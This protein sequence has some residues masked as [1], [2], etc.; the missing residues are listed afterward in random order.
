MPDNPPHESPT[1]LGSDKSGQLMK[2]SLIT[3]SIVVVAGGIH[4][5]RGLLTPILMATFFALILLIPFNWLRSK[6]RLSRV[7]AL[8]VVILLTFIVSL[9]TVGTLANQ[10]AQFTDRLPE[11]HERLEQRLLSL[12]IHLEEYIPIKLPR[13]P[14]TEPEAEE[15]SRPAAAARGGV[16]PVV[17]LRG[18]DDSA[19]SVK[20]PRLL[21][22]LDEPAPAPAG[23][24][25][26]AG[27][28]TPTESVI[29]VSPPTPIKAETSLTVPDSAEL[30]GTA[31]NKLTTRLGATSEDA[32][33][34]GSYM[35]FG[36]LRAF[37]GEIAQLASNTL[38]IM[39]LVIFM[40]LES[41]HLPDKIS[42]AL[43]SRDFET[44]AKIRDLKDKIQHYYIIK[45]KVSLITGLL[46]TVVLTILGV[47][48]P[49]LWGILAFLLNY[50]P[51]IG[52]IVAAIPPLMLATGDI[53]I[54]AGV[55]G[56][57]GLIGIHIVMG[58]IFEPRWLG[59]GLDLSALV[60]LLSLF[61]SG[62]FLGLAGVFLAPPLAVICKIILGAFP[63]S[64]WI[65]VLMS[66]GVPESS[67]G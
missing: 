50:I 65:A 5:I 7:L 41:F 40:L 48:Y 49:L 9:L 59:R 29:Q 51:N 54:T 42:L 35:L 38:T 15:T 12:P 10:L 30:Q 47:Q 8:I 31:G 2:S 6:L 64:E 19:P 20:T 45:T 62:W 39:I 17:F 22:L 67:Q 32:V 25:V 44:S 11:Y 16:R 24:P 13:R 57:V 34:S 53:G 4:A 14:D 55:L 36:F 52:P 61:V 3:A 33:R 56:A 28:L 60:V 18:S 46:S 63:E 66:D 37:S 26:S 43:A 23:S 1:A 58:Y 21:S 27:S